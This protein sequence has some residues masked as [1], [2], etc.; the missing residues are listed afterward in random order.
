M[1]TLQTM[2]LELRSESQSGIVFAEAGKQDEFCA[3]QDLF[4]Q[5]LRLLGGLQSLGVSKGDSVIMQARSNKD[6]VVLL[7]AC[8]LGG[9]VAV[10]LTCA[11]TEDALLKLKNVADVLDGA[12][13]VGDE[14]AMA[15]N[16]M[17]FGNAKRI[18][19]SGIDLARPGQLPDR[20]A[21]SDVAIIQ[22]SSGTTGIPKGVLLTNKNVA[23]N[24][25]SI[26]LAGKINQLPGVTDSG[27]SWLPLTNDLGLVGLHFSCVYHNINSIMIEP[28]SF[29]YEP[30]LFFEKIDKYKATV[31]INPNFALDYMLGYYSRHKESM[32]K[33]DLSSLRLNICG[34]EPVK[35]QTVD[36]FENVFSV[37][38][39]RRN[40]TLPVY[41]LAEA[42]LAVAFSEIDTPYITVSLDRNFLAI[43]DQVQIS[44]DKEKA[45]TFV[46]VGKAVPGAHI[47]IRYEKN[48]PAK[49]GTVG[50]VHVMGDSVSSGYANN[51]EATKELF[52]EDGW[53]NTYDIG[54]IVDGN[55]YIVGRQKDMII[56][57]GKNCY[58]IDL[59]EAISK[60]AKVEAAV[61]NCFN[62]DTKSDDLYVFVLHE[63]DDGILAAVKDALVKHIGVRVKEVVFRKS[64]PRTEGGKI[65]RFL[66]KQ[67]IQ[68]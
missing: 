15:S 63:P 27:I 3:Y 25:E 10:P 16:E 44:E 20:V 26:T 40:S 34:S 43:G 11:R 38:S 9:V 35:P 29:F 67:E 42:C 23:S 45:A 36:M 54:V 53:L 61:V 55:L 68:K 24:L 49:E 62:V 2:L 28:M 21:E 5:S 31:A 6:T 46:S 50:I 59:E 22:F 39:L 41:G 1:K 14:A 7:W 66:L 33:C 17:G 65:R 51:E 32:G 52:S 37:F 64:F 12:F 57:H 8:L 48:A 60:S 19:Y 56:I 47:S 13:I 18:A 4:Q 30:T 58:C